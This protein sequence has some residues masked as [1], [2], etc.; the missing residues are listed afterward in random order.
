MIATFID[1]TGQTFVREIKKIEKLLKYTP[2]LDHARMLQALFEKTH[3]PNATRVQTY[4]LQTVSNNIPVY[5]EIIEPYT[6]AA[7]IPPKPVFKEEQPEVLKASPLIETKV[8]TPMVDSGL[9]DM[10]KKLKG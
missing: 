6:D 1:L 8:V 5:K 9:E 4:V 10:Y 2:A 3:I 7:K